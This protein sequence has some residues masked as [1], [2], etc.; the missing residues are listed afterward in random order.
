LTN[1]DYTQ[2]AERLTV[3]KSGGL[4]VDATGVI[5]GYPVFQA[6]L[7]DR[8]AAQKRI[9][10]CAGVHGDEPAGPEAALQFLERDNTDL[11][12]R[13][14]FLVLPCINP[15]GYVHNTRENREGVDVNRSF[16][17]D[18]IAEVNA[19]KQAVNGLRFD[20][21][22]DFHED[23]EA[24]GFYL[25]EGQLAERWIA[26]QVVERV[27]KIG[28]IDREFDEDDLPIVEGALK[29]DPDWGYKGLVS[30]ILRFHSDHVMICETPTAW[31]LERRA[32]AHLA[33][34]DTALGIYV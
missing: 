3:L 33:A 5:N 21:A 26:P 34:L 22:I 11:L 12:R 29:V 23:W 25:F 1:R 20:F 28:P 2:F 32:E 7:G 17:R 13:F 30:Y 10:I 15:Y 8:E 4:S 6:W 9:L 14:A 31:P 24:P 19:V 27:E 16:E 18:D